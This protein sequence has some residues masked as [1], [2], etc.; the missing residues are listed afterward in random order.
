MIEIFTV[1]ISVS[2]DTERFV[3]TADGGTVVEEGKYAGV[4]KRLQ[5]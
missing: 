1:A 5:L 3:G 2:M 4:D